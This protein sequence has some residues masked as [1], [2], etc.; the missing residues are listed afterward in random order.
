MLEILES[1]AMVRAGVR[2]LA[3]VG[4]LAGWLLEPNE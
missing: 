3:R 2:G 1:V 4:S